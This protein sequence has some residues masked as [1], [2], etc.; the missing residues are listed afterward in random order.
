M[1]TELLKA[2]RAHIT[3]ADLVGACADQVALFNEIFNGKAKITDRNMA[4]ALAAGLSVFW[5][6]RLIPAAAY[7][8]YERGRAPAYAIYR[9]MTAPASAE[10][11]RVEAA[12]YAEY[13]R[14][15]AKAL[16][17]ALTFRS[18]A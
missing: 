1:N 2:G 3:S 17:I 12:A 16:V 15:R 4:R 5:L 11:E 8:E 7:V 10:Y 18:A 14:V 13:R 6:E 9:R